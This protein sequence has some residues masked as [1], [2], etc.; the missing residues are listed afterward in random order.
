MSSTTERPGSERRGPSRRGAER[1]G[2]VAPPPGGVERR[3]ELDRRGLWR[4]ASDTPRVPSEEEYARWRTTLRCLGQRITRCVQLTDFVDDAPELLV[5][6]RTATKKEDWKQVCV[7][8]GNL[9]RAGL[10][11]SSSHVSH[12]AR[13]VQHEV[14]SMPRHGS[15]VPA[16]D[17]LEV[18]VKRT[19]KLIDE[20]LDGGFPG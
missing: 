3:E 19:S 4:R 7:L 8:A 17:Q 16:L 15:V 20:A 18:A 10:R 11:I 9:E 5:R 6:L 12:D 14:A 1:R 2:D 13:R